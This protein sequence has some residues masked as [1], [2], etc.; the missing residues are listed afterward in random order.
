MYKL[1][2]WIDINKISWLYLSGNDNAINT[3]EKNP[4]IINWQMLSSNPN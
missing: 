1:R 2:S 4:S 3:L